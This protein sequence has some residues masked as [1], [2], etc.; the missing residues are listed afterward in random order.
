M[1]EWRAAGLSLLF[2][3]SC[4]LLAILAACE[5][6]TYTGTVAETRGRCWTVRGDIRY[7]VSKEDGQR[8]GL[9]PGQK[10]TIRGKVAKRQDCAA[11]VK[12]EV[13]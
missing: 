3:V 7:A 9:K 10:V 11:A 1:N 6:V 2:C 13:E 8:L 12:L 4:G 5:T